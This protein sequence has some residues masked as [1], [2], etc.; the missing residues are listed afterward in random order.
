MDHKEHTIVLR[1][2]TDSVG[3]IESIAFP[4]PL[5]VMEIAY[6]QTFLSCLERAKVHNTG[7]RATRMSETN[8]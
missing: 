1:I 2:V 7:K 4:E 3:N 6:L 8:P 5:P